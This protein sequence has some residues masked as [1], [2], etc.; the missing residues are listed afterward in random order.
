MTIEIECDHEL[1]WKTDI[2]K[3]C[4]HT[5]MDI[6]DWEGLSSKKKVIAHMLA[7]VWAPLKLSS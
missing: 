4:Y 5:A 6:E 2:C 3:K 1:D 7:R